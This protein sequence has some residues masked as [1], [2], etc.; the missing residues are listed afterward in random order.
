MLGVGIEIVGS[1]VPASEL[2]VTIE[3]E[4]VNASI[5]VFAAVDE[6]KLGNLR[7]GS[8]LFLENAL[9][10]I[11]STTYGVQVEEN[12]CHSWRHFGANL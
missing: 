4:G 8:L 9:S 2:N 7:L 10:C 5:P 1:A 3:L 12:A 6:E 11:L